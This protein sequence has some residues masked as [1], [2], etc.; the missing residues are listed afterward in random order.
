VNVIPG[1]EGLIESEEEAIQVYLF[2]LE[3]TYI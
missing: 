1:Y 3:L 2:L